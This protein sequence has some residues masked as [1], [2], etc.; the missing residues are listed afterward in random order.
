[1]AFAGG[2]PSNISEPLPK[3]SAFDQRFQ[4]G[5]P[6]LFSAC[7][8][9]VFA[10]LNN[11]TIRPH[12]RTDSGNSHCHILK[13]FEGALAT[14]PL[15]V[16]HRHDTDIELLQLLSFGLRGPGPPD[17]VDAWENRFPV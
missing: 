10:V 11:L 3:V 8:Q 1:M 13:R 15:V 14:G 4:R 16:G 12:C 7:K 17:I 9:S 5:E 2:A 6:F